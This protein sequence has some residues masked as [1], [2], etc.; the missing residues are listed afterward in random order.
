MKLLR[1]TR[2][3]LTTLTLAFVFTTTMALGSA[4]CQNDSAL[5]SSPKLSTNT[6]YSQQTALADA[7]FEGRARA[8]GKNI[9]GK[10]QETRGN[11][12]GNPM[13]QVAGK[14]KQFEGQARNTTED[15]KDTG[16]SLQER[17]GATAKNIQGKV[18]DAVG[19]ITGN[20]GDQAAGKI[21]Q[22]EGNARNA[23]EDVRG[24]G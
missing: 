23:V 14:S 16:A 2:R 6:T 15:F 20:S 22:A 13:D 10:A 7:S 8:M 24:R 19:S 11:I 12:T 9:E 3:L 4:F 5:A 18:Q 17:A 1:Y 21:K